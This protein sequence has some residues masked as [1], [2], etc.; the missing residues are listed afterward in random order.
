MLVEGGVFLDEILL[1]FGNIFERMNRVGGAGW[2][3]SAAVNAA[4]GIY[5]HLSGGFEA[6]LV[7]LGVNAIGGA[8]LDTERIFDA[9]ISDYI[10]HDESFS[11]NEHSLRKECKK[12]G[13]G[14]AVML[15]TG[16][17]A[18]EKAG[19]VSKFQSFR[20]SRWWVGLEPWNLG[21]AW[22]MGGKRKPAFCMM[23]I[24]QKGD[25]GHRNGRSIGLK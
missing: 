4:F 8:D 7:G 21:A 19:E 20:V 17:C 18:R 10:S 3:T 1:L 13:A 6:G 11:W 24:T 23:E 5:I 12:R 25:H 14:E 16:C 9:G 2:D 22:K 15:V